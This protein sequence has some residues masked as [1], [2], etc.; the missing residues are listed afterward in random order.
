MGKKDRVK[1][2]KKVQE[3]KKINKERYVREHCPGCLKK[4]LLALEAKG[5]KGVVEVLATEQI[6][7]RQVPIENKIVFQGVKNPLVTVFVGFS[8]RKLYEAIMRKKKTIKYV[9]IIE[10]DLGVF[11]HLIYTEDVSD[12][13][14]D[15][16]IDF[17]LGKKDETIVNDF[18]KQF[19]RPI[20]G[21]LVSRTTIIESMESIVDPFQYEGERREEGIA[22][23][24][25]IA[26]ALKQIKLAMGCSDDQF[27]RFELMVTNKQNM[28]NAWNISELYGK[29]KDVP[30]FVLGGGPSLEEF[31]KAYQENPK[32]G[33][34]SC[35]IAVDAV[36]RRLLDH[37]I[38]PHIVTRCE[39]KLTSIFKGVKKEDTK[40]IYYAAYP[41]TPPEFFKLFDES[42]YLFRRNG[43]CV[44]TEMSHGNCDGGVSSGNA[45]LEL[46][47][48]LGSKNI[49]LSGLDLCMD[50][51]GNTHV[52]GTQVEFDI[53][54]SKDKWTKVKTNSGE[55][56]TTIPV[57]IRCFNEYMQAVGKHTALGKEFKVY[58]AAKN[59]AAIPLID[60]KSF[61]DLG[62]LFD[63]E[64]DVTD[65]IEKNRKRIPQKEKDNFENK[66]KSSIKELKEIKE[67]VLVSEELAADAMRTTTRELRK[68]V[69]R[70]LNEHEDRPFELVKAIRSH[71]A[72][73]EKLWCGVADAYDN[74]FK[75]KCY[76]TKIFQNLIFDVLQLD[77]YQY[78][79]RIASMHNLLDTKDERMCEYSKLTKDFIVRVKYYLDE[80]INLFEDN[81]E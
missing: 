53:N 6:K 26:T 67:S 69:A 71:S 7:E 49:I 10:P 19:T 20:E 63:K 12:L 47:I 76:L 1:K 11:K 27:R 28:F 66:L 32:I 3:I 21:E 23:N 65:L 58:N 14:M 4:N 44:Y 75:K 42:F 68:I 36:L 73:Y 56:R 2:E 15:N 77:T 78:E 55:E 46:G 22:I 51:E 38:R 16:N 29:F 81:I 30:V 70:V 74:N 33:Q 64:N 80:F 8:T 13:I 35:I 18:F 39:R 59:G 61:E 34:N 17:I 62:P 24:Q 25:L 79:N 54:K 72:N 52:G 9:C 50:A 41:W 43:V 5:H 40:G 48:L 37:G 31:I 60:Y 57:W 45:A